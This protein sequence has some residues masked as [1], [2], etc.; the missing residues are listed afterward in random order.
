MDLTGSDE[1]KADVSDVM[2]NIGFQS[3]R[4]FH[5]PKIFQEM[6]N[7]VVKGSDT[8]RIFI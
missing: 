2:M 3:N 6:I 8:K 1:R 4:K 5:R 7:E